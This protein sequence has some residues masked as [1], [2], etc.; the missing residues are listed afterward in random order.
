MLIKA[1]LVGL[2]QSETQK[3][4]KSSILVRWSYFSQYDIK[5]RNKDI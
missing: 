4:A 5:M 1:D 2:S 3:I